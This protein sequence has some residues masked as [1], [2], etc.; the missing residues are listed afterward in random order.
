MRWGKTGKTFPSATSSAPPSHHTTPDESL[1]PAFP[2]S[3]EFLPTKII[4]KRIVT[5]TKLISLRCQTSY[6][7]N[8]PT[9]RSDFDIIMLQLKH[10]DYFFFRTVV[11][12]S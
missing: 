1:I 11:L 3:Q 4:C 6:N 8:F 9:K 2:H 10:R 5:S 7:D 12:T